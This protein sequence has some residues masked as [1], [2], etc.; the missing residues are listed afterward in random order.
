M[1]EK[2][3]PQPRRALFLI[4]AFGAFFLCLT[5]GL[6]LWSRTAPIHT[7]PRSDMTWIPG[8]EF[9]MG[10]A[11]SGDPK[12]REESP[13][14]A[15]TVKGFWMDT[16][17]VTNAQFKKFIEATGY[18]TDAEK[19]LSARDFPNAPA[20]FLKG[21][22]LIFKHTQG[23]NPYQCGDSGDLPWWKFTA[24][25]TWQH[26]Q[27][28]GS[29][30]EGR[31]DY[32]VICLTW[33]DVHAYAEWIGKRLPTEAEWE[34]AA[35]GGL[36]DK[37]YVWG[38]EETPGGKYM[39]NYWQGNFPAVDNGKDGFT[40]VAPVKSFPPNG[41]GLYDMSGNVWE[42]CEDWYSPDFYQA[43]PN[44]NPSGPLLGFDPEKTG[45]AQHVIRGGSWL[46]DD[47]YC[48]RFRPAARQGLDTLTSTNHV[49]FRCVAD[50]PK[51]K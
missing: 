31:M 3:S 30:I 1:K 47:G 42:M 24:G 51:P 23:I 11:T 25:A 44:N 46:C 5:A 18:I 9:N 49:G 29:S 2:P 40:Q 4:K 13:A 12:H 28:P 21:G 35:R 27:G 33:K 17:E 36:K 20:E 14:H 34:F 26:P 22:S 7:D 32:P 15:V 50:G 45:F 43:S 48:F 19:D 8:G 6:Y 16:T 10:S 39:A 41:Y 37:P 38:D